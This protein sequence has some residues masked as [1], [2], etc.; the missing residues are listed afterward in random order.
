VG[1]SR[2]RLSIAALLA[3]VA[4]AAPLCGP[5]TAQASG[6]QS[7]GVALDGW[8]GL[9]PF[10]GFNLSTSNAPY[11]AGWDIAR[12][13]VVRGA[14]S[15]GW[16]LDG[17][18]GIN[19]FGDAPTITSPMYRVNADFARDFVVTS[20]DSGGIADGRQGY[21]LSGDGTIYPWGG[22]PALSGPTRP[23]NDVA[24]GL[25]IHYSTTGTPDGGWELLKDGTILNLGSAPTAAFADQRIG[26]IW[27]HLHANPDS[28]LWAV[29]N[30]GAAAAVTGQPVVSSWAGFPDWGSWDIIRDVQLGPA[31]TGHA[32]QQLGTAASA[33]YA[34]SYRPAGGLMLDGWGGLSA[35]GGFIAT[36]R[37][38]H[39]W[40]WDIARAV[41]VRED[42][43]GGWLLDGDGG[44]HPF[45]DAAPVNGFPYWGWDIARAL[46]ITSHDVHGNL[47]AAIGES[48][49]SV[50]GYELDG[51]GGVHAFGGAPR[52][53][54][55]S[56]WPGWDI[57]TGLD[58]H[59]DT[60][61]IPD[62]LLVLDGWGGLH[63][64]GNYQPVANPPPYYPGHSVYQRLG[65]SSDGHLYAVTRFGQVLDLGTQN[66]STAPQ[67]RTSNLQPYWSG[68]GDWGRWDI[69]R[70]VAIERADDPNPSAQPVSAAAADEFQNQVTNL[71]T[72]YLN[73]PSVRM[74]MPLDCEAAATAAALITVG[75]NRSQDW[76]FS[77]LPQQTQPAQL[78]NGRPAY[79][80]DAWTSF[81]GN[82]WGSEGNFTGYGVYWAPIANIVNSTGHTAFVGP[83]TLNDLYAEIDRG[84][85]VIIW[86]NNSYHYVRP[87]YWTGWDGASVPYTLGDHAVLLYGV[88]YGNGTVH[89]MDDQT[90]TFRTFSF[91]QFASFMA[92]YYNMA[93]A[94]A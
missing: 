61:G 54:T 77:Q 46:V 20:T 36:S 60:G 93:V 84:R 90:G 85:P 58:V 81:V 42:G 17:W 69:I 63:Y 89:I 40:G 48:G 80:G 26:A 16:T 53:D 82:V 27:R 52:L 1:A 10:G 71:T 2:R 33:A 55:P 19:G 83:W 72:R 64:S 78:W 39:W 18:G 47:G 44:V 34:Q 22:A 21:L 7:G 50:A 87:S 35:W 6:L 75:V 79:W 88:D 8:G 45:G 15:G 41:A 92:T 14:G 31:N 23:G 76:V 5:V 13:L 49:P 67:Q 24:R 38:P 3:F 73:A 59:L 65:R 30:W 43:S 32:V 70:D 94:V 74:D 28:T 68:Y 37:S 12:A 29:A 56:Y 57:A 9:H 25:A 66:I 62:G 11:W 86:I 4:V 51:W 91:A